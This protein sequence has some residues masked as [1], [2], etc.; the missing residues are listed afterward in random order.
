MQQQ[1]Q[2][3]ALMLL[4]LV[5]AVGTNWFS[6]FSVSSSRLL[7]PHLFNHVEQDVSAAAIAG[8]NEANVGGAGGLYLPVILK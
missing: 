7:Q 6:T 4:N 5:D 3:Y 1:Q 2:Q 8:S